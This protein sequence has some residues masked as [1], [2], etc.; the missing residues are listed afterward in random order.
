M[1]SFKLI[2]SML[3]QIS[4]FVIDRRMQRNKDRL[5]NVPGLR[6]L[7]RHQNVTRQPLCITQRRWSQ[8]SSARRC[9]NLQLVIPLMTPTTIPLTQGYS[10]VS[11]DYCPSFQPLE[12]DEPTDIALLTGT[13]PHTST[14]DLSPDC[15]TRSLDTALQLPFKRGA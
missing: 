3:C 7:S 4:F 13:A 1:F 2:F 5:K 15:C 10:A 9:Q 11:P 14:Q 12:K 6:L 8:K